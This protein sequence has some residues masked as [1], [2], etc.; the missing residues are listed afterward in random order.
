MRLTATVYVVSHFRADTEPDAALKLVGVFESKQL[1]EA[2]VERLKREPGFKESPD[3]FS[4]SPFVLNRSY[5]DGGFVSG[6]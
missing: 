1:A 3:G 4:I 6:D 5:W 2:T